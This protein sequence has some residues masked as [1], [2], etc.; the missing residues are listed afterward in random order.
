MTQ[1]ISSSALK[2]DSN[3]SDL[4]LES[5]GL[6][7]GPIDA[8][9][10]MALPNPDFH[11]LQDDFLKLHDKKTKRLWFLWPTEEVKI[12]PVV[13]GKCGCLG[14][15]VFFG[16]NRTGI[17]FFNSKKPKDRQYSAVLKVSPA[18]Q[19]PGF[20]Q[21][22]L[23]K[24]KL[25]FD[26]SPMHGN[27]GASPSRGNGF[28]FTRGYMSNLTSPESGTN[29]TVIEEQS[30]FS[31]TLTV[32]KEN[33]FKGATQSQLSNADTSL[34]SVASDSRLDERIFNVPV[35]ANSPDDISINTPSESRSLASVKESL[36][37]VSQRESLVSQGSGT[38]LS[39]SLSALK[40][41]NRKSGSDFEDFKLYHKS[42]SKSS[43]PTPRMV[44]QDL[45]SKVQSEQ[46][47][48]SE[49]YYSADEEVDSS[50]PENSSY[51]SAE[52]LNFTPKCKWNNSYSTVSKSSDDTAIEVETLKRD[53]KLPI[54]R[55][56]SSDSSD[57]TLSY[58][59]A[60]T[61]PDESDSFSALPENLLV[62]LHSQV[63]KPISES[64]V[65]MSCYAN[66]LTQYQ[67]ND[68][69][70]SSP[71]SYNKTNLA[72]YSTYSLSSAGQSV[73]YVHSPACM[74]RFAKIR[75]G[76]ST[77]L[78]K[79][80]EDFKLED[81]RPDNETEQDEIWRAS[82]EKSLLEGLLLSCYGSIL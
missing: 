60:A 74:P 62:D 34:K 10:A 45:G 73:Q 8:E 37:N 22:L 82:G 15:C 27:D 21:S 44:R 47:L 5:G 25:V 77:S 63:Q 43:L 51:L 7:I 6:T 56:F 69:S 42:S 3:Q 64:P 46:S 61:E 70:V 12:L 13:V 9:A 33:I 2:N 53:T 81:D 76:F 80:R 11:K 52:S 19:D 36:E 17:G 28:K 18:G 39:D 50:P 71:I 23:F 40:S 65:L 78:M 31:Q 4:W 67:C 48:E 55:Q 35:N 49:R 29:I 57:S 20:G 30:P 26:V 66:H 24:D 79:T 1:F 68:W 38:R 59:S 58:E 14:G 16:N 32:P 75:Q 54:E 41:T 72:D